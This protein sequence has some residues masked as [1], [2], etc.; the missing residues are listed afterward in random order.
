MTTRQI[1]E[2]KK[3]S[4]NILFDATRYIRKFFDSPVK[5]YKNSYKLLIMNLVLCSDE[6]FIKVHQEAL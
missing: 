2:I 6:F 3:E 5:T 1:N 4:I